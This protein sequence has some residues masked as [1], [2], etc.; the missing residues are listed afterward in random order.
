MNYN[1]KK[2]LKTLCFLCMMIPVL[3][4]AR[5]LK[6]STFTVNNLKNITSGETVNLE[7]GN[8]TITQAIINAWTSGKKNNVIFKRLG[9]SGIVT[10][11]GNGFSNAPEVKFNGWNNLRLENIR[12]VNLIPIFY[13]CTNSTMNRLVVEGQKFTGPFVGKSA[14]GI[15]RSKNVTVSNCTIKW[16]FTGWTAKGIKFWKGENNKL[17]NAT[18]RGRLRGAVDASAN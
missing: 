9:S 12:F 8:Y 13:A 16:T 10:M 4:F 11:N 17:I 7:S 18:I 5:N 15:L 1:L 6:P 3:S 2:Q 14:V